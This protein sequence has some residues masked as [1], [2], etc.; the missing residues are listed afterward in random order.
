[1]Y[2]VDVWSGFDVKNIFFLAT[3]FVINM[4]LVEEPT[5]LA[6]GRLAGA[7]GE[8]EKRGESTV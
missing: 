2:N 7:V 8:G 4:F 3:G 5:S 6:P 1:M